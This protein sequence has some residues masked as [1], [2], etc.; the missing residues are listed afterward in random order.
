MLF[1]EQRP[2][3]WGILGVGPANFKFPKTHHYAP[4]GDGEE[5][6]RARY[7]FGFYAKGERGTSKNRLLPTNLDT[8]PRDLPS[9]RDVF[10]DS[11]FSPAFLSLKP[12]SGKQ[13]ALASAF[14]N[15]PPI[16]SSKK[17]QAGLWRRAKLFYLWT[18]RNKIDCRPTLQGF[19]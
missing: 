7:Y 10:G 18:S 3:F 17:W 1:A 16:K 6:G 8:T 4:R 2:H 13:H 9:Y 14:F 5:V 12:L 15:S 19:D 11:P